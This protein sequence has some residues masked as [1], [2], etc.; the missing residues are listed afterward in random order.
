MHKTWPER[1]ISNNVCCESLIIET[2]NELSESY[3]EQLMDNTFQYRQRKK[4]FVKLCGN[5]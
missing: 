4:Y 3:A 2:F 1:I 5:N